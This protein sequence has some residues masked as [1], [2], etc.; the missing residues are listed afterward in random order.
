M[1]KKSLPSGQRE[2]QDFP[3]FGVVYDYEAPVVDEPDIEVS[4]DVQP[5]KIGSDDL[6]ALERI[7][8]H[9]DFHCV[10]TWSYCGIT[11]S[12]YRFRDVYE[13]LIQPKL[14]V[15]MTPTLLVFRA[16]DRFRGSLVINDALADNVLIA[17][18]LN[19]EVLDTKH[20]APLRLVAP[21]HYGYKS[22]KHLRK[23]E[24]YESSDSYRPMIP[25]F[26][27]HPRARIAHEE[28]GRWLPGWMYRYL[29]RPLIGSTVRKMNP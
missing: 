27:E 12:G 11:W 26:M 24:I 15:G 29:Y 1:A 16:D 17:D 6:R 19:G 10:T 28:R 25:R 5:F 2:R 7:E 20:G 9:T 14:T 13:Q 21:N 22:V 8:I 23:V 3:R 4:G 18:T